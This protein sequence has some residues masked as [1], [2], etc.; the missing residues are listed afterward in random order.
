M[1]DF[2]VR[3]YCRMWIDD[4]NTGNVIR[5]R[6]KREP[7][8][9]IH[10]FNDANIRQIHKGQWVYV[11]PYACWLNQHSPPSTASMAFICLQNK[12]KRFN[13][14]TNTLNSK[15][16]VPAKSAFKCNHVNQITRLRRL[17]Q[18]IRRKVFVIHRNCS[19]A[20]NALRMPS[21][22]A[23]FHFV[24]RLSVRKVNNQIRSE[25]LNKAQIEFT[26]AI[27]IVE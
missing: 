23:F 27:A 14:S 17:V 26:V 13:S 18:S 1:G 2:V 9:A 16:K 4:V 24:L 8:I 12:T 5:Q 15:F 6:L 11:F 25:Q 20:F 3:S 10:K 22:S 21:C 19:F 7:N